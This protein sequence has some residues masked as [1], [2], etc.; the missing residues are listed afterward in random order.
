MLDIKRLNQNKE[1][2]IK[3]IKT[4]LFKDITKAQYV[5]QYIA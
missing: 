2:E 4:Q 1:E 5:A 3:N